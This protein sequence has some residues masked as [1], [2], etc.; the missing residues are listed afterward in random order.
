[1]Y[2]WQNQG[3]CPWIQLGVYGGPK[4]PCHKCIHCRD[5]A[6]QPIKSPAIWSPEHNTVKQQRTSMFKV[7]N[8]TKLNFLMTLLYKD[9][10]NQCPMPIK[11]MTLIRNASQCRSMPDQGISKTLAKT[12]GIERNWS[13]L[14]EIDWHWDQCQN[15]DRHWALMEGVLLDLHKNFI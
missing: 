7:G 12:L 13:A 1:M 3:I 8:Q 5:R 2:N 15:S 11:S 9:S 6:F 4:P 14:I 10:L